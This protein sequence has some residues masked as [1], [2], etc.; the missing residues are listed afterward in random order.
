V[1]VTLMLVATAACA[2][3]AAFDDAALA[4]Q[5]YEKII[6]PGYARFDATAG[7]FAAKADLLCHRPTATALA[8][9]RAAA[10]EALAAFGSIEPFRFGPITVKQRLERLLFYPDPNGLIERQ[11]NRLLAGQDE[12]AIAP[13][14]LVGASVAVQGFGAVD[15]VLYS[16]GSQMLATDGERGAFRCRYLHALALGIAAIARDTHAEW[17]G[18]YG[19]TW[20]HPGAGNPT[21]LT[22]QETTQALYR[23]YVTEL[24]VL[25]LQRLAVLLGGATK[26]STPALPLFP[27]GGLGLE[28]ILAGIAAERDIIG[29]NGFLA[30]DLASNDK[31]RGAL[32]ILGSVATDLGFAIRAGEAAAA[33][34]S[35]PL[36]DPQ[37]RERLA[38]LLLSL[39][40]AEE[41]GRAALAELTGQALGFN[42]LD[43]D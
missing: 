28:F 20:L 16:A 25:R 34:S 15:A 30:G 13:E 3:A 2:P 31:E 41:T 1:L 42:S 37:A 36:S 9:T 24:E 29:E 4:R 18:D 39:K 40:N 17:T 22:A 33:L 32:A 7:A 8:E 12:A 35:H 43:G 19:R 38:P 6:L 14:R 26:A 21:Y 23:A 5:T 11:T 10:R 27:H